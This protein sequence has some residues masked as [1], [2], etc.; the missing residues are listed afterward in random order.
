ME[1]QSSIYSAKTECPFAC[2]FK[3]LSPKDFASVFGGEAEQT[4]AFLLSFS[5]NRGYAKKVL[6]ILNDE[7]LTDIVSCYL[8]NVSEEGVDP[9]FIKKIETFFESFVQRWKHSSFSRRL[10]KNIFIRGKMVTPMS[11]L[12][13]T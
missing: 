5:C 8:K 7:D 1:N 2:L 9:E 13:N 11:R 6:K 4:I 12:R 10:R 3:C